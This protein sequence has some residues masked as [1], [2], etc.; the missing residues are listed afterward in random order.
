MSSLR[1]LINSMSL[2]RATSSAA[3]HQGLVYCLLQSEFPDSLLKK[4]IY[5]RLLN[6]YTVKRA[7][8]AENVALAASVQATAEQAI[9]DS[10]PQ[11]IDPLFTLSCCR[12]YVE[13]TNITPRVPCVCCGRAFFVNELTTPYKFSFKDTSLPTT[14]PLSILR[15][16]YSEPTCISTSLSYL[17]SV[18][19]DISIH[20][21][22]VD[23]DHD[24]QSL[25]LRMCT[26]CVSALESQKI[27]KFSLSN[28]LFRGRLPADLR[29]IT[30]IEEKVCALHRVTA[31][32]ARLQNA[33]DR[34]RLRLL[35]MIRCR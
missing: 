35:W 26:A 21:E 4:L 2:N 23:I 1:S 17:S 16:E 30:W 8:R 27:P 5:V 12:A 9:I 32:V 11:P 25:S 15:A 34:C 6:K 14:H 24:S 33:E 18:L 31:D 22:Y 29:D 7:K 28:N 13:A 10:W 20:H 19:D 3:T